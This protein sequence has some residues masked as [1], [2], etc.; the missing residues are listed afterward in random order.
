VY[1]KSIR[2]VAPVVVFAALLGGAASGF[3]GSWAHK[4]AGVLKSY[5]VS[6]TLKGTS[7]SG[8]FTGTLSS[9]GS[10]GTLVWKIT[11]TPSTA[12]SATELRVGSTSA[13]TLLVRLCAPC[14]ASA[15][16]TKIVSGA[17]VTTVV[18]GRAGVVVHTANGTLTG[19]AKAT[20]TSSGG[21]GLTIVPTPA[22]VANGKSYTAKFS[23]GGCHTIDG[24]KSSGP[25][26][27]GLAG[28]KV[29]LTNGKTIIAT[30]SYLVGVIEDP[31]T[32]QVA[33]YDP[34]LMQSMIPPGSVSRSQ[35][36]AIVA[37]I[38]SLK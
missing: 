1:R 20:S 31:S 34:A 36:I 32:L 10:R 13:G 18:S 37:Y 4:G 29:H 30:D 5:K 6:A 19:K 8:V 15:H 23:C 7:A 38:K 35:A 25:T 3:A 21:G 11:L 2:L 26:W 14:A 16:G 12:A 33:G 22:L 9:S 17:T 24:T 28:S 27:K